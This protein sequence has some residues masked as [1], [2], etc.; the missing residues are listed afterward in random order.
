[1][2][3]T[4]VDV[5]REGLNST[6]AKAQITSVHGVERIQNESLAQAHLTKKQMLAK[7]YGS[8]M[9]LQMQME[10][11]RAVLAGDGVGLSSTHTVLMEVDWSCTCVHHSTTFSSHLFLSLY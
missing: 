4:P 6:S 9:P 1:M 8:H 3:L 2:Q 11:V 7:V 5:M 10:E